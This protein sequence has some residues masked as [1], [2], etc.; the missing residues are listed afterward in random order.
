LG[1]AQELLMQ[2]RWESAS[3]TDVIKGGV[4]VHGS[5]NLRIQVEGPR[6]DV[7]P[8]TALALTM[9]LHELCTNAVKYGALS[10]DTGN[11]F[12]DWTL[13][14]SAADA[15]LHLRWKERGGPP[16]TAP[17]R[18]GFGSRIISEYCKFEL[19]GD[20]ALSFQP[21]GLEWILDAPLSSLRN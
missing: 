10:N 4:A 2:T 13:S 12:L 15:R 18:T 3:I 8:N 6:I 21:D 17:A 19:G 7:G 11:V 1:Q 5:E 14:G 9:A 16:V 20:V